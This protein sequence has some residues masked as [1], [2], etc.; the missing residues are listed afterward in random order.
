VEPLVTQP[1]EELR[2]KFALA[3]LSALLGNLPSYRPFAAKSD[4]QTEED[5]REKL[6]VEAYRLADA[7]LNARTRP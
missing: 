6:A 2:D 7:M 5:A 4:K 3:A 1:S